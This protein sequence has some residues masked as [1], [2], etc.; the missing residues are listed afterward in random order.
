ML[1]TNKEF[2]SIT[3]INPDGSK[4]LRKVK[5]EVNKNNEE[6]VDRNIK[7]KNFPNKCPVNK[8]LNNIAYE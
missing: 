8:E 5:K 1:S 7:T 2:K 3:C 6:K 4:I